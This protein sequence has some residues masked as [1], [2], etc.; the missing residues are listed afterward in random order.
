MKFQPPKIFQ[1]LQYNAPVIL[2]FSLAAIGIHLISSFIPGFT[3]HFFVIGPTM[4]VT[5]P[6]DYVRLASHTLGHASWGH[7]FGNLTYILLLGPL[8]EEK[9]G[10]RPLLWMM[11]ATAVATGLINVLFFPTGLMGASSIVF[12]LII[13]AS[14]VN[15]G[16]GAVPLTFVL[17]T[18]IFLGSE[19]LNIFRPDNVSQMAHIAGGALGAGFGFFWTRTLGQH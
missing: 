6:L 5:N 14:I 7:L 18:C 8:L 9:Y 12:M 2:T 3:G 13:L 16:R 1:K 17:V 4:S 10:S 15:V 19:V 11:A